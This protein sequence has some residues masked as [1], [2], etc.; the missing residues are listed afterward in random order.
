ML[1]EEAIIDDEDLL[2]EALA[3]RAKDA[4]LWWWS[5]FSELPP[6]RAQK[7]PIPTLCGAGVYRRARSQCFRK[8]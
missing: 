4:D 2:V 5:V 7:V 8:R 1:V 3:A 6:S